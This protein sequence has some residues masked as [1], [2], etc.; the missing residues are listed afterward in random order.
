MHCHSY[1]PRSKFHSETLSAVHTGRPGPRFTPRSSATQKCPL[2]AT[3]PGTSTRVALRALRALRPRGTAL[4]A[5]LSS[6]SAGAGRQQE[7][8]WGCDGRAQQGRAVVVG[9]GA[10]PRSLP[11]EMPI[12]ANPFQMMR[13]APRQRE[14]PG[15]VAFPRFST[16]ITVHQQHPRPRPRHPRDLLSPK[17]A[18]QR[19][20]TRQCTA[21]PASRLR[22]RS[23]HTAF[24]AR[25]SVCRGWLCPP[26]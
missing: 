26:Y 18:R 20:A 17:G 16:F 7:H 2:R 8:A 12:L 4:V 21:R 24:G 22:D 1:V 10:G 15:G 13:R 25:C 19:A 14:P 3:R 6:G 23:A 9:R 11:E 5:R